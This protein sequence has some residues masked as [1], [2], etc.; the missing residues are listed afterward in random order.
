[1][2]SKGW[3][4]GIALAWVLTA[5]GGGGGGSSSATPAP[6]PPATTISGSIAPGPVA[7]A[8]VQLFSVDAQGRTALLEQVHTGND[9]EYAFH[10]TPAADT[11]LMVSVNGGNWTDPLRKAS[12]DVWAGTTRR[13]NVTPYTEAFVRGIEKAKAPN[14]SAAGVRTAS[15]E[16]AKTLGVDSLTDFTRLDLTQPAGATAPKLSD[17]SHAVANGSFLGFWHRLET[18]P[19]QLSLAAALDA[20]DRFINVDPDDDR[21]APA[22]IAGTMDFIDVTALSADDKL[23]A[24]GQILYGSNLIPTPATIAQAMPKGV[25]SG[26]GQAPMPDDQ[27]RLV[28]QPQGRTHFNLRGALVSYG[29]GDAKS[30]RSELYSASVAEVFA[31]GDVGVGRWNGGVQQLTSPAGS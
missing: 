20:L 6:P 15:S 13:I 10:A 7:G 21:L 16:A 8:A 19:G 1:M 17:V 24:K 3:M 14:W 9:G 18:T 30:R 4:A 25:S 12:V 5:C 2:K 22:F 29:E 23:A 28:G 31:D 11:V 27:F 26:G